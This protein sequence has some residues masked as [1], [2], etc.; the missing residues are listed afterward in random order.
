MWC[1]YITAG[2]GAVLNLYPARFIVM[3]FQAYDVS[4]RLMT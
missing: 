4:G 3:I 2:K 1:L